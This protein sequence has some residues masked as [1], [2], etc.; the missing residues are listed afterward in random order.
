MFKCLFGS[1]DTKRIYISSENENE[2]VF[3]TICDINNSIKNEYC[4]NK[5]RF[6]SVYLNPEHQIVVKKIHKYMKIPPTLLSKYNIN[7]QA[8]NINIRSKYVKLNQSEGKQRFLHEVKMHKIASSLN[9]APKV[10][11][12]SLGYL[13]SSYLQN[14]QTVYQAIKSIVAENK[15]VHQK[16]KNLYQKCSQAIKL[17]NKKVCHGDCHPHN[18]MVNPQLDVKFV[19]FGMAYPIEK[20][21]SD[22]LD[23]FYF[24]LKWDEV[25]H[26]FLNKI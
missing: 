5:G 12:Y 9:L 2:E 22:N 20:S 1:Y 23:L 26:L 8:I 14:Y 17:L 24:G 4:L 7:N 6:A 11:Y 19:D 21:T 15:D 13:V 16:L 3:F 25:L 18:L 10:L